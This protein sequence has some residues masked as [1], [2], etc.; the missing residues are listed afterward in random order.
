MTIE[1][2]SDTMHRLTGANGKQITLVGTAHVSSDSVAE[3]TRTIE[4]LQ[5]DRICVE[6]DT[7][8]YQS[9]Q[10]NQSWENLNI[11]SVLRENKGFLLIANMALSSYQ[12]KLGTQLGVSP[13]DD[14]LKAATMATERGIPL[15]FCDREIQVTFKRA[16][17]LSNFWNKIKLISTLLSAMFFN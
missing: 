5:P 10:G 3:V 8:R 9:K 2:L 1:K 15:S 17:R 11:K 14:I 16:L 7:G 4:E 12:K 6:L 13:G